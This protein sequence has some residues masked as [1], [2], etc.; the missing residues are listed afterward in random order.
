MLECPQCHN[1]NLPNSTY[2]DRCGCELTKVSEEAAHSVPILPNG[3]TADAEQFSH[4]PQ[5]EGTVP[6][7]SQSE[8]SPQLTLPIGGSKAA[9]PTASSQILKTNLLKRNA[10]QEATTDNIKGFFSSLADGF[11]KIIANGSALLNRSN[12]SADNQPNVTAFKPSVP[13]ESKGK[14]LWNKIVAALLGIGVLALCILMI[15]KKL[16]IFS[17]SIFTKQK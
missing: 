15:G 1:Q 7:V 13:M 9:L 11:Q 10:V 12:S 6:P 17:L 3:Q 4:I 2:C 8:A 5:A 14:V 16:A